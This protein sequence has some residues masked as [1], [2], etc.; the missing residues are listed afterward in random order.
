MLLSCCL[1]SQMGKNIN[2]RHQAFQSRWLHFRGQVRR[3]RTTTVDEISPSP[4]CR[5]TVAAASGRQSCVC[6]CHL[7]PRS[8]ALFGLGISSTFPD[9]GFKRGKPTFLAHLTLW[10]HPTTI[11]ESFCQQKHRTVLSFSVLKII[12]NISSYLQLQGKFK[13]TGVRGSYKEQEWGFTN[14]P[15]KQHSASPRLQPRKGNPVPTNH[16]PAPNSRGF[17][18]LLKLRKTSIPQK[19]KLIPVILQSFH[20][21]LSEPLPTPLSPPQPISSGLLLFKDLSSYL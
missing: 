14:S 19:I 15:C 11:G 2:F 6:L 9:G 17:L 3:G 12:C 10:T 8:A 1:L 7:T 13:G 5:V 16:L 20:F 18:D 4:S 21:R